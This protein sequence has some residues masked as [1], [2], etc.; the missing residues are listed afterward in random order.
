MTIMEELLL[1]IE[2]AGP[3]LVFLGAV[4]ALLFTVGAVFF[5]YMAE[6]EKN[7]RKLSWAEWPIPESE[8]T[9]YAEAPKLRLAA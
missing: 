5:G 2:T 9:T 3:A 7:G 8:T 1:N 4:A 6:E